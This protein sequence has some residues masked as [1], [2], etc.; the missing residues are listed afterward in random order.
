MFQNLT[1]EDVCFGLFPTNLW[2]DIC[3]L[4][5]TWTELHFSFCFELV[6]F[7]FIGSPSAQKIFKIL[8]LLHI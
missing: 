7:G 5:S 1:P 6:L 2:E 8:I 4:I 3:N